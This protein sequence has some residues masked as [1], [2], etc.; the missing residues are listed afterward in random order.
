MKSFLVD[1]YL[2]ENLG[3]DLFLN[4]IAKS[5]PDIQFT[6]FH[7]GKN[8]Q[9]FFSQYPNVKPFT[10]TT[11]DKIKSRFG[12]NK[13]QDYRRLAA[14]YDALLFL[15]GGIFREE[16]YW[17]EVYQYR[18]QIVDAF[19]AENKP[20]YFMGCNFGPYHTAE[21]LN[22]HKELFSKVNSISF[23]DLSSFELFRDLKTA[24]FAPDLLWAY[25]LPQ[26]KKKENLIGISVI[27]P[28]HKQ[29][30]ENT[31][32]T[33]I[34]THKKL[35]EKYLEEGKQIRIFSFCE[36]EGDFDIANEIVNGLNGTIEIINYKKNI[37]EYLKQIGEC[38]QFIAARFHAV[39]IALKFGINVVPIIY[40]DK[41]RNLLNDL[42]YPF[43]TVDLNTIE[44]LNSVPFWEINQDLISNLKLE[45]KKHL[46]F[47]K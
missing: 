31:Y 29:G 14:D 9:Y 43:Q 44:N 40:G 33:Y 23:R 3:D 16:S 42:N 4:Y 18:T 30:S 46:N 39:I 6:P 19:K 2:A 27:N 35:C 11:F 10:Y 41:T 28:K 13:L 8:Y 32:Q 24:H 7:P 20:V 1:I 34:E 37:P 17:K 45:S 5:L 26:V 47:L 25:G 38:N 36:K 22:H 12:K 15:G 21:F